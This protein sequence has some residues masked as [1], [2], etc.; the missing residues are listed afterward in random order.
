[1]T[2]PKDKAVFLQTTPKTRR[3]CGECE[4]FHPDA[5]RDGHY[6]MGVC[7]VTAQQVERCDWCDECKSFSRA[8]RSYG[9]EHGAYRER[10]IMDCT[11]GIIY[12]S[13]S[14]AARAIGAKWQTFQ[15]TMSHSSKP[16]GS[17]KCKGHLFKPV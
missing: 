5:Q 16:D 10:R 17:A 12:Q 7:G 6:R 4:N 13:M 9:V 14:Q 15:A 8:I 1:M 11:T 3:L 2:Q